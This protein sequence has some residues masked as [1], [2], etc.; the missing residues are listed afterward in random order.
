MIE[1]TTCKNSYTA[2]GTQRNWPITFPYEAATELEFYV[3]SGSELNQISS[4]DYTLDEE[5]GYITYP[6]SNSDPAVTS[7]YVVVILRSTPQTQL[8]DSEETSF[9]SD[10]IERMVD[11]LTYIAQELQE[12]LGRCIMFNVGEAGEL[13]AGKYI[14]HLKSLVIE[15]TTQAT[16]ATTQAGIATTKAGEAASSASAASTSATTASKWAEGND[17]EVQALGGTHSAKNWAGVAQTYA[18]SSAVQTVATNISNVNTVAGNIDNVNTV[19]SNSSNVTTVAGIN[20]AVSTVATNATSV[21]SVAEDITNINAVNANK[22]NIDT[23]A[24]DKTNIDNVATYISSVR[25]V[26]DDITNVRAV[27]TDIT[28]VVAVAE[29]LTNIDTAVANLSDLQ[30]KQN[31][32]LATSLTINGNTETTVEGALGALNTSRAELDSNNRLKDAQ[33]PYASATAKGAVKI[34]IDEDMGYLDIYTEA[35]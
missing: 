15:A 33:N 1:T 16:T 34:M 9:K 3:W 8:E 26:A 11:K 4:S 28:N 18:E 30:D 27:A 31:K 12:Q 17:S 35:Y 22:T 13:D 2:N 7:G 5:E 20:A 29:D 6:K 25:L 24:G 14:R 21:A 32:T 23:V 19:A 10:D